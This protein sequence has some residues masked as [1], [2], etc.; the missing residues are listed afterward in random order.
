VCAAATIYDFIY[1]CAAI[2]FLLNWAKKGLLWIVSRNRE[3]KE[4][5]KR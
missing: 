4:R 3:A 1:V 2:D 5:E